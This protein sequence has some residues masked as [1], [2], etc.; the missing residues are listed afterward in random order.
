MKD[1]ETE[2]LILKPTDIEDSE[3]IFKIMNTPKYYQYIGDRNIRTLEDAENY[4]I[5]KMFPQHEKMGFGNYTVIL[6]SD[7]SKIGF[8]GIYVRPNLET[9]D[10]GFAF[11]EEFEGKGYAYE[12][13]SLL[14]Q[15]AKDEFG[16]KKL[17]G[18]TVEYNHSSRKLLEKLGL[19]FQKKFFME[20]DPE[21][22]LY[23]EA[24]L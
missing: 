6:K 8:C 16:L 1:Y 5:Q 21:E 24:E 13:A 18:I 22:L 4:I 2:R 3:F 9:P 23:Y 14:K 12:A 20:G 7:S 15:L 10:I 19:E 11:F 17:G